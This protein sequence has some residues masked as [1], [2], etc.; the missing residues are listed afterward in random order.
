MKLFNIPPTF[1]MSSLLISFRGNS[2]CVLFF[3][4]RINL[5]FS[6]ENEAISLKTID[7]PLEFIFIV[8]PLLFHRK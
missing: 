1:S 6:I 3:L 2:I 4:K 8:P 7:L 5:S